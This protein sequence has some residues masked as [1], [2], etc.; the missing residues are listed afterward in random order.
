MP[1][2]R[3]SRLRSKRVRKDSLRLGAAILPSRRLELGHVE[4]V[5]LDY[6][7]LIRTR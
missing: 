5:H 4:S 7:R 2:G 3:L 6:P 1:T